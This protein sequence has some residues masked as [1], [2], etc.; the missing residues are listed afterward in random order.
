MPA[1]SYVHG[2]GDTPL[3]GETIGENLRRTV[4]RWGEREAL[5][6]LSQGYRATWRRLWEDTS[7]VAR[8]LLALGVHKG[9]RVGLWSPNRFEWVLTQ[10]AAA[11]IGAILVNLNPAYKTAELRYAL[12]QSGARVLLLAAGFRQN[13]YRRMLAEVRADCPALE[14]ALVLE[15]DWAALGERGEGVSEA[16]LAGREASR[17]HP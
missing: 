11:R 7:R 14:H 4:E 12:N 13:D 16:E 1:P 15:D 6:V 2:L 9:D 10:Y 5:V 17:W 3:L 8:G